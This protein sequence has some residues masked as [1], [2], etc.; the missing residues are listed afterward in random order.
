MKNIAEL[1]YFH[2][3]TQYIENQFQFE[4]YGDKWEII[5]AKGKIVMFMMPFD[6]AFRV[7]KSNPSSI[8]F[9][10]NC[11]ILLYWDTQ[12]KTFEAFKSRFGGLNELENA[13]FFYIE[14]LIKKQSLPDCF[15][16]YY[17]THR[18]RRMFK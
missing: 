4:R 8:L 5:E 1:H 9:K 15:T 10:M 11:H 3:F 13:F 18:I 7:D 12:T 6:R 2:Q 14:D 17:H 16:T